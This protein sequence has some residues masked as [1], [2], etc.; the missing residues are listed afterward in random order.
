[1]ITLQ[2]AERE[3]KKEFNKEVKREDS[4]ISGTASQAASTPPY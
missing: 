3:L 2:A 1:M 4:S